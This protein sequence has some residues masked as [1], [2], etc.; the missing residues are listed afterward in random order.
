MK[1]VGKL[2]IRVLSEAAGEIPKA[3]HKEIDHD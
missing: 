2:R 3:M 1:A